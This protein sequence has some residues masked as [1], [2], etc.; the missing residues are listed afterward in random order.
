MLTLKKVIGWWFND[1]S[2]TEAVF[3]ERL[4]KANYV[5]LHHSLWL[6]VYLDTRLVSVHTP[7]RL[8]QCLDILQ[9]FYFNGQKR[10]TTR[11]T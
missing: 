2:A 3:T 4:N 7:F 10:L 8:Y 5:A 1:V 11:P 6:L 9:T